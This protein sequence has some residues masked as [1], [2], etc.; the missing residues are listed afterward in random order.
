MPEEPK[1]QIFKVGADGSMDPVDTVE[2]SSVITGSTGEPIPFS[3]SVNTPPSISNLSLEFDGAYRNEDGEWVYDPDMYLVVSDMIAKEKLGKGDSYP[4]SN[5]L[6]PSN[7]SNTFYFS[8][9]CDAYVQKGP[10]HLRV[11]F[12]YEIP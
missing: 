11:G 6:T 9:E 10:R 5:R 1:L 2:L 8:V 7:Y 4:I 3:F 12:N